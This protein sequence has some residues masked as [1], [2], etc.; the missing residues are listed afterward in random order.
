MTRRYWLSARERKRRYRRW[1]ALRRQAFVRFLNYQ[2]NLQ[3]IRRR[4]R[5][6]HA[7]FRNQLRHRVVARRREQLRRQREERNEAYYET[8]RHHKRRRRNPKC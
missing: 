6:V 8:R 2:R 5:Y 3:R 4:Q 7:N 1:Q